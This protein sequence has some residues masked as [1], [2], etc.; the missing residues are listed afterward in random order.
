MKLAC[1][2]GH[3]LWEG[4]TCSKCGKNRDEE[5]D[6][7]KD[8]E[9]CSNCH[10]TRMN[11]HD[12]N[13]CR[14]KG[15]GAERNEGHDW[16]KDCERC[17]ICGARDHH[18]WSNSVCIRC[19][20]YCTHKNGWSSMGWDSTTHKCRICDK[21]E[22]HS[23][24]Q[25][26][27]HFHICSLC[28]GS[29]P[30]QWDRCKCLDCGAIRPYRHIWG[31]DVCECCGN[32][33][34]EAIRSIRN[35]GNNYTALLE[36]LRESDGEEYRYG[37]QRFAELGNEA[38]EFYLTQMEQNLD[39]RVAE[40]LIYIED[41]RADRI[42]KRLADRELLD[43]K[44]ARISGEGAEDYCYNS[45]SFR[46]RK[47][48]EKIPK[49]ELEGMSEQGQ[50]AICEKRGPITSFLCSDENDRANCQYLAGRPLK[51]SPLKG[52]RLFCSEQCWSQ[53]AR[54]REVPIDGGCPYFNVG[55]CVVNERDMGFCD[56]T[57]AD[58]IKSCNL[59]AGTYLQ[60][61]INSLLEC[62][63]MYHGRT[64]PISVLQVNDRLIYR[65]AIDYIE[66]GR[67]REA[68]QVLNKSQKSRCKETAR[69]LEGQLISYDKTVI[70]GLIEVLRNGLESEK[71]TL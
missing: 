62:F 67:I 40:I 54:F 26:D 19:G 69:H 20:S 68:I 65:D 11:V 2:I 22:E 35:L 50:C 8:C 48:L 30:H 38:K 59:Y 37:C 49:A 5:H 46:A 36:K 9:K 3:H 32:A 15:C 24:R 4:C 17:S 12:W 28:K 44:C 43:K 51:A 34:P 42:L 18:K 13:G 21:V 45:L 63:P 47:R 27:A 64:K 66:S 39:P 10:K 7:S 23:W 31:L 56:F 60:L 52:G 33:V 16:T 25:E 41:M 58:Y 1:W 70:G 61:K 71:K 55:I 14:C 29:H 6:W 53:R 57:G